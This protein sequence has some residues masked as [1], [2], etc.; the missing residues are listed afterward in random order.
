MHAPIKERR[1]RLDLTEQQSAHGVGVGSSTVNHWENA[2]RVRLPF[3]V[4]Q[5]LEMKHELE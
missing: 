1:L 4:R 2:K 3:L 5:L